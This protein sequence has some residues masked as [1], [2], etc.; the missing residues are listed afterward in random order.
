MSSIKS[1]PKI[2][3]K[4]KI[5]FINQWLNNNHLIKKYIYIITWLLNKLHYRM[6]YNNKTLLA[7][8]CYPQRLQILIATRFDLPLTTRLWVTGLHCL[9]K[10]LKSWFLYEVIAFSLQL[11]LDKALISYSLRRQ[12][13]F[14]DPNGTSCV[15]VVHHLFITCEF[16][17]HVC[18][19]IW[20]WL[21]GSELCPLIYYSTCD[22][23][24]R[25]L[26]RGV[27]GSDKTNEI[28]S[29]NR[30]KTKKYPTLFG[31]VWNRSEPIDTDLVWFGSWFFISRSV[32][33]I[34]QSDDNHTPY[35][36]NIII[37]HT[38]LWLGPKLNIKYFLIHSL[39]L[40]FIS[41]HQ[42]DY[43]IST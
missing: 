23:F 33:P 2:I 39:S 31:S 41:S 15:F 43:F 8:R 16:P 7:P 27:S 4:R 10:I 30:T 18:N 25:P 12:E 3:F 37:P 13:V 14:L 1:Q 6:S 36:K 32:K 11:L 42:S 29:P 40:I 22:Q 20:T 34:N 17:I 21:G 19:K 9:T 28:E 35:F 26:S 38:N 24:F 5:N